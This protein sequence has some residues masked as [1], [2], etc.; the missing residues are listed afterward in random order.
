M[1]RLFYLL[2]FHASDGLAKTL[3]YY[4]S[5]EFGKMTKLVE[6]SSIPDFITLAIDE[7]SNLPDSFTIC[8][9]FMFKFIHGESHFFQLYKE[10]GSSW[11]SVDMGPVKRDEVNMAEIFKIWYENPPGFHSFEQIHSR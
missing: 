4:S 11:F 3:Q 10:D 1:I 5:F 8:S 9:S 7:K 6:E 2:I